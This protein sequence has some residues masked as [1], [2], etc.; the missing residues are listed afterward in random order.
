VSAARGHAADRTLAGLEL[1]LAV[2]LHDSGKFK[3]EH[4]WHLTVFGDPL[5]R[6]S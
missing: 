5:D 4:Q 2:G 6:V 1:T 3:A